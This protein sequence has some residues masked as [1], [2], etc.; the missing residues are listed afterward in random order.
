MAKV[1]LDCAHG[2]SII[3]LICPSTLACSLTGMGAAWSSTARGFLH[4]PTHWHAEACQWPVRR[5][6]NPLHFSL[7]EWPRLPFTARINDPSKL[8]SFFLCG[9]APVLAPLRP[10]SEHILI[11]RAPGARDRH[12]CHSIP[13]SPCAFCEQEGHL[14]T[15]YPF[16]I[17]TFHM[18][19]VQL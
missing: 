6:S 3:D 10:S 1:A 5:P 11:V 18:F 19:R 15:P 9:M 4:P 17:A 12:G 16:L 7:R 8:A 13:L 2:T 14:A